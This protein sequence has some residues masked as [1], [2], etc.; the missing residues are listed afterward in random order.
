M[1]EINFTVN[2]NGNNKRLIFFI[3]EETKEI[4]LVFWQGTVTIF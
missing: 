3:I 1:Q 4:V 2:L